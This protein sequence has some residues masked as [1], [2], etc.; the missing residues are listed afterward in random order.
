V[1]VAGGQV[2]G[3]HFHDGVHLHA[4]ADQGG[5]AA[6]G[7]AQQQRV[8]GIDRGAGQVAG[9]RGVGQFL[10]QD[11]RAQHGGAVHARQ[12]RPA[13]HQ[14]HA[15]RYQQ[16]AAEVAVVHLGQ[17]V[18]VLAARLQAV[19]QA[20][21]A[22]RGAAGGRRAA[23][24]LHGFAAAL[25]DGVGQFL[26]QDAVDD[27]AFGQ[28][29]AHAFQRHRLA[30]LGR[31]QRQQDG[32]V[33]GV[34]LQFE[35][36]VD[37]LA[38]GGLHGFGG[39]A[40]QVDEGQDGLAVQRLGAPALGGGG[41]GQGVPAGQA[42]RGAR[43]GL[44]IGDGGAGVGIEGGR[45]VRAACRRHGG[46]RRGGTRRRRVDRRQDVA[47]GIQHQLERVFFVHLASPALASCAR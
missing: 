47:R 20:F 12:G 5:R 7:G 8:F 38:D 33:L 24:D 29:L 26:F 19:E 43:L 3:V 34:Q 32:H 39:M 44:I 22:C 6:D 35:R 27:A 15:R 37:D 45:A 28:H 21:E 17:F 23:G 9:E 14:R 31:M 4:M 25:R 1:D 16:Q 40:A 2:D 11:G 41:G 13:A 10:G 30:A 46:I 42:D 36:A 18:D